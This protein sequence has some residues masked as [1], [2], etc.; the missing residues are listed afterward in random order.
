MPNDILTGTRTLPDARIRKRNSGLE[1][2]IDIVLDRQVPSQSR[3]SN[4]RSRSVIQTITV[5]PLLPK[6]N[7]FVPVEDPVK[8]PA[9]PKMQSPPAP[10]KL[11]EPPTR[12]LGYKGAPDFI[13]LYAY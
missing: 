9:P 6:P 12:D 10:V 13:R 11:P 8:P 5:T 7:N 2:P 1:T 4:L 3:N